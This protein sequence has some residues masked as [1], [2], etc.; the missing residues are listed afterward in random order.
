M[1]RSV[2]TGRRPGRIVVLFGDASVVV[3]SFARP[4]L[5]VAAPKI[6]PVPS[7]G[8]N[9]PPSLSSQPRDRFEIFLYCYQKNLSTLYDIDDYVL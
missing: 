5:K 9:A 7:A 3:L 1:K 4:N 8:W 6:P 2:E